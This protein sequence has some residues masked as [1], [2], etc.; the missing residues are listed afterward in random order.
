M[1][2]KPYARRLS[3]AL[4]SVFA[5]A[6]AFAPTASAGILVESATDCEDQSL[7]RPFLPWLD[8][9]QYTLAPGGDAESDDGWD[10]SGG[11]G[12]VSGN[13]PWNVTSSGDSSSMGMPAGSSATTG[14]MCVGLEHPTLR[15]FARSSGAG[16]FSALRV[17]VLVE[18]KLGVIDDLTLGY[19][20]PGSWSPTPA[21]LVT[22]NLLP[23]LPGSHTPVAF[24]FTPQ[25][26]GNWRIDDVYVDPYGRH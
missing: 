12:V 11:A 7:S 24:R 17:E 14:A 16:L 22:A 13:E 1:M 23:L 10:L 6:A 15:F 4:A 3:V 18:D 21:Y 2:H 25:G 8:A 19:V 26:S 20:T 9:A 5:I